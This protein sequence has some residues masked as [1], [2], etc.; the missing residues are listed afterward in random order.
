[1]LP[2]SQGRRVR[3]A[4]NRVCEAFTVPHRVKIVLYIL[5]NLP[6]C[7][8]R[9]QPRILQSKDWEEIREVCTAEGLPSDAIYEVKKRYLDVIL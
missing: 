8:A 4:W 7:F 9:G 3:R 6:D 5:K 2:N 1:M